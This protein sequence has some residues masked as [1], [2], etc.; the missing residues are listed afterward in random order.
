[1]LTL[2]REGPVRGIID[3]S[4]IDFVDI[5]AED[6]KE[7]ARQP[8]MAAGQER[9]F[10]ATTPSALAFARTYAAIQRDFCGIDLQIVGTR[11]DACRLLG[12]D[13]AKFEPLLLP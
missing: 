10:V 8:P 2:G 3:L 11:S 7:R 5:P 13:D 12:A 1:M 9:I 6:L 4:E